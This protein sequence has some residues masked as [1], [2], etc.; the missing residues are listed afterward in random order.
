MYS[1]KFAPYYDLLM[2][3]YSSLIHKTE[4]LLNRYVQ[5]NNAVLELGCG[6]GNILQTLKETYR[7]SGLDNS[8]GMLSEAR[9]KVPEALLYCEDMASFTLPHKYAA[10]LCIFDSINHLTSFT[11]WKKL[12]RTVHKHLE[13]D[14]IFI[15]DINTNRRHEALAKLPPHVTKIT[16]DTLSCAKISKQKDNLFE[17]TFQLFEHITTDEITYIE[18]RVR[19]SS[20]P[21]EM[22]IEEV[23]KRFTI[24]KKRGSISKK[25]FSQ[26]RKNLFR[27]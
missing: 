8:E 4:Q 24:L 27:L 5:K 22:I 11:D 17:I 19:E 23:N 15:F 12:F 3:D 16:K 7:V 21:T 10:I 9:K 2:G 14:G 18:E 20:F 13:K 6:T 25:N 26:N 1:K